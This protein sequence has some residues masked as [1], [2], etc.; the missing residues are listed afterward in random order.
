M[1]K[2]LCIVGILLY[3]ICA[4]Q[5]SIIS[6]QDIPPEVQ[7]LGMIMESLDNNDLMTFINYMKGEMERITKEE[8]QAC[9]RVS[10]SD[11]Y[12]K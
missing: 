12:E 4:V 5:C 2:M 8:C 3:A 10:I 9:F 7:D 6:D 11:L 1:M